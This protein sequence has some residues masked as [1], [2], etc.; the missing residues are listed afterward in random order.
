MPVNILWLPLHSNCLL[1]Q[2]AVARRLP[3]PTDL[4]YNCRFAPSFHVDCQRPSL[5][6]VNCRCVLSLCTNCHCRRTPTAIARRRC[7]RTPLYANCRRRCTPYAVTCQLREPTS[8]VHRFLRAN[9]RLPS[10]VSCRRP[11]SLHYDCSRVPSL[12]ANCRLR[13]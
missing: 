5:S 3:L 4:F 12:C 13:K 2:T 11:P 9:Y 6:H 8:V 7:A 1:T 10:H